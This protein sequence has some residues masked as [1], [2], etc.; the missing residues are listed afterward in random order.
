VTAVDS[1]RDGQYS[2]INTN[3]LLSAAVCRAYL[4]AAATATI[5]NVGTPEHHGPSVL[6]F[7]GGII[8]AVFYGAT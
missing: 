1:S 6:R 7:D 3:C 5:F 2:G 8:A 4:L